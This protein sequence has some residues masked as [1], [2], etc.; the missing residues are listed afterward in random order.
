VALLSNIIDVDP[1]NYEEV[2][3]KKEWKDFMVEEYQ[4]IVK[5]DVWDVVLRSKE[6]TM[7]SSK[8]IYKT[9]HSVDGSIDKYKAR[10][11]AHG[12]SQKE[13]IY[14]ENTFSPVARYTS[15]RDILLI[16]AVMKWKV[17]QMDV[18]TY[19]L[20]GVL[21]EEVYVVQPQGFE[22]HD[23]ETHVCR[24]NKFLYGL[25]H[26]EHGTVELAASL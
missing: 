1:T 23:S 16:V 5:N 10:F 8:W 15:I 6:K 25:N 13:G 22:T 11:V 18:K 4:S 9:K 26:L 17:H 7:V 14:Y 20:N 12:F 24:L 21:G 19:F 2:V 3:E